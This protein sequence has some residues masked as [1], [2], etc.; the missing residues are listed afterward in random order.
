MLNRAV[1]RATLFSKGGGYAAFE[2]ILCQAWERFGIRSLSYLIMPNH[3]H[4]V[5]WPDRPN[6]QSLTCNG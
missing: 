5:V 2:K 3:S 1:G 4:L 6:A